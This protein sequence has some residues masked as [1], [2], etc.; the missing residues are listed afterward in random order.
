MSVAVRSGRIQ[1]SGSEL[2]P[3][4]GLSGATGARRH[5]NAD[6]PDA[7]APGML[8]GRC[9]LCVVVAMCC[10]CQVPD[11]SGG[12]TN[13]AGST[14]NELP[15]CP[16]STCADGT[17][18]GDETGVDCGGSC[19]ACPTCADGTQN[20]DETGVDCGGS[21]T[22]CPTCTNTCVS[23]PGWTVDSNPVTTCGWMDHICRHMR[24][25]DCTGQ[26]GQTTCQWQYVQGGFNTPAANCCQCQGFQVRLVPGG[27]QMQILRT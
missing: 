22:A 11:G 17:Q 14:G 5:S 8:T 25:G 26:G 1:H 23:T 20:G 13:A 4:P 2:L 12:W 15:I 6:T 27:T 9:V 10:V 18:N 21:C 3:M 7:I 16:P 19:S 24:N